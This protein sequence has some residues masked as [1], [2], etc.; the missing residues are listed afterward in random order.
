MRYVQKD[1][2]RI[3]SSLSL[4]GVFVVGCDQYVSKSLELAPSE[5]R[6]LRR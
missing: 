6:L 4:H 1:S 3:A 2:A 5:E